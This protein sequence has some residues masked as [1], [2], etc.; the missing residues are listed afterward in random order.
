[1]QQGGGALIISVIKR[2][3]GLWLRTRARPWPAGP[4][5]EAVTVNWLTHFNPASFVALMQNFLWL[6]E[7]N[8]SVGG[9]EKRELWSL[10]MSFFFLFEHGRIRFQ[11]QSTVNSSLTAQNRRPAHMEEGGVHQNAVI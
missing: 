7:R 10:E 3:I 1:M 9:G 4:C 11:P 6:K 5:L 2:L 8:A